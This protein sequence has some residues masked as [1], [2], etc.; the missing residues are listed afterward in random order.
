M[1]AVGIMKDLH[2]K[3]QGRKLEISIRL[4]LP[5]NFENMNLPAYDR[6]GEKWPSWRIFHSTLEESGRYEQ[7]GDGGSKEFVEDAEDDSGSMLFGHS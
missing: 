5:S 4:G 3:K 2:G 1:R 6:H 7:W